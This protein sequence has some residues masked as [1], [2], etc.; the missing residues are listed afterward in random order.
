MKKRKKDNGKSSDDDDNNNKYYSE[1]K[2]H[3]HTHTHH[4][5]STKISQFQTELAR[6]DNKPPESISNPN[7]Q[8]T[9]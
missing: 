8:K 3:S 6:L 7:R 4:E 5:H 1:V 2:T 9:N